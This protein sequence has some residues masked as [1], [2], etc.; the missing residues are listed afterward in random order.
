[1]SEAP[2]RD[3]TD[4]AASP[5]IVTP[6]DE[7]PYPRWTGAITFPA[8]MHVMGSYFGLQ[9][10]PVRTCRVLELACASGANL[11]PMAHSL[12]EAT[13]VGVDLSGV[14]VERGRQLIEK[15]GLGNIRLEQCDILDVADDFGEFDYIIAHGVYSWVPQNVQEQIFRICARHLSP[16]GVAYISYNTKPGWYALSMVREMML[17]HTEELATPAERINQARA[18]LRFVAN[19]VAGFDSSH[20]KMLEESHERISKYSD[21]YLY[22]ELLEAVN[23][24]EYFHEFIKRARPHGLEF[25][26]EAELE[27]NFRTNVKQEVRD[28][29][30]QHEDRVVIE[31]YLDFLLN[32]RFRRTLLC[33]AENKLARAPVAET[34]QKFRAF[35]LVRPESDRPDVL[36]ASSEA[37]VNGMGARITTTE[38]IDKAALVE[39]SE[40][41]PASLSFEE[42]FTRVRRRLYPELVAKSEHRRQQ[43]RKKLIDALYL[44]HSLGQLELEPDEPRYE[45]SPG[46][47]PLVSPVARHEVQDNKNVTNLRHQTIKLDLAVTRKLAA[48]CDGTRTREEL[49]QSLLAKVESGELAA[50]EQGKPVTDPEIIRRAVEEQMDASLLIL[51]RNALLVG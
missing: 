34:V 25:I 26:H 47:R 2:I 6:Y 38:P 8:R 23:Q 27:E 50:A 10:P 4:T 29:L 12:P 11:M 9:P 22:H 41:V 3:T 1:M 20:A 36:S 51:A 31:Q 45:V 32:R 30:S 44:F 5:A 15:F 24:P 39:L 21:S 37:F 7:V 14:Q 46:L 43:D 17:Y 35:T 16:Q 49:L 28:A 19:S 33:R 42:L 48:L 40:S 13:F 18:M